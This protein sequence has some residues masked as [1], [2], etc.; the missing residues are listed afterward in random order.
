MITFEEVKE[1]AEQEVES[2]ANEI[3]SR[4]EKKLEEKM[5]DK[6]ALNE[7]LTNGGVYIGY[8]RRIMELQKECGYENDSSSWNVL[9]E[10][11]ETIVKKRLV[12]VGWRIEKDYLMPE[13]EKKEE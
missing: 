9:K 7:F 11:A 1:K 3:F 5:D 12:D 6:S 10:K 4:I 2:V 8:S 13:S